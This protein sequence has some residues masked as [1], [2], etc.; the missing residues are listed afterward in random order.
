MAALRGSASPGG[1]AFSWEYSSSTPTRAGRWAITNSF[2]A[3]RTA[4]PPGPRNTTGRTNWLFLASPSWTLTRA[5]RW[6]TTEPLSTRPQA[7]SRTS[8]ALVCIE[9]V[10]LATGDSTANSELSE[11]HEQGDQQKC[12]S[13]CIRQLG[14][15]LAIS[16]PVSRTGDR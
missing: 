6:A 7:V 8:I 15:A 2:S 12:I 11:P 4:V 1:M 9:L 14:D 16:G 13:K 5:G 3:Q 10:D